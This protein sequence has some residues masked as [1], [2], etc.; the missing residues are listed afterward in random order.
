MNPFPT[1]ALLILARYGGRV[2]DSDSRRSW[3]L[4][5]K[6]ESVVALPPAAAAA[7]AACDPRLHLEV[8]RELLED[9]GY[10]GGHQ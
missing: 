10:H 7:A 1:A 8:V 5:Q 2:E 6:D 4:S 3:R 9:Q